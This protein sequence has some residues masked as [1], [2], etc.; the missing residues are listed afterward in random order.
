MPVIQPETELQSQPFKGESK[1]SNY[2]LIDNSPEV[3]NH[4]RY[5]IT[6]D[7]TNGNDG[8]EEKSVE[9]KWVNGIFDAHFAAQAAAGGASGHGAN[10]RQKYSHS[11]VMGTPQWRRSFDVEIPGSV[12]PSRGVAADLIHAVDTDSASEEIFFDVLTKDYIP[13]ADGK[14]NTEETDGE[15]IWEANVERAKV[16]RCHTDGGYTIQYINSQRGQERCLPSSYRCFPALPAGQ[17]VSVYIPTEEVN[18]EE[19]QNPPSKKNKGPAPAPKVG[20]VAGVIDEDYGNGYYD[21]ALIGQPKEEEEDDSQLLKVLAGEEDLPEED[22]EPEK[23]LILQ[24]PR[25]RIGPAENA[26][27]SWR[28]IGDQRRQKGKVASAAYHWVFTLDYEEA[29]KEFNKHVEEIAMPKGTPVMVEPTEGSKQPAK[30]G[31]GRKQGS[32]D[33][34]DEMEG[35]RLG[36]L[37]SHEEATNTYTIE[38]EDEPEEEVIAGDDDDDDGDGWLDPDDEQAP[39]ATPLPRTESG[40][41]LRRMCPYGP[42]PISQVYARCHDGVFVKGNVSKLTQGGHLVDVDYEERDVKSDLLRPGVV[43]GCPVVARYMSRE[44]L[45]GSIDEINNPNIQPQ[46]EKPGEIIKLVPCRATYNIRFKE[47]GSLTKEIRRSVMWSLDSFEIKVGMD[48]EVRKDN[49]R[50]WYLGQVMELSSSSPGPR[51]RTLSES[52]QGEEPEED[53]L[54]YTLEF[55]D[56]SLEVN[57]PKKRIREIF[58]VGSPMKALKT[59]NQKWKVGRVLSHDP[60]N[61]H[62]PVY[63]VEYSPP[64]GT[65]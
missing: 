61:S 6:L 48:V 41:T 52:V 9:P 47:S 59:G 2:S 56:G 16:I 62:R 45:A 40:V 46:Q 11:M 55:A 60:P 35:W 12:K 3:V 37:L 63:I 39:E 29:E 21:I 10:V 57:V 38:Y 4:V 15:A 64:P 43:R 7:G 17:M 65:R 1:W 23:D 32:G 25:Q 24:V 30:M 26:I 34:D 27:I 18:E 36:K 14:K 42:G 49:G 22:D 50:I 44:R 5:D 20:W 33:A 8:K 19:E 58:K 54:T 51:G 28:N 31:Y 13:G 53:D